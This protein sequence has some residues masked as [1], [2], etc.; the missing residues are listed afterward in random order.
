MP[1]FRQS[2]TGPP[3]GEFE[4]NRTSSQA[5]NLVGWW[6]CVGP[7]A[8]GIIRDYARGQNLAISASM[9][10]VAG[11]YGGA[12]L[13]FS[14]GYAKTSRTVT[15]KRRG[16]TMS[17]WCRPLNLTFTEGLLINCGQDSGGYALGVHQ[18]NLRG[19]ANMI[20]WYNTTYAL[21]VDRYHLAVM[22]CTESGVLTIYGNGAST[23]S[24][25]GQNP[26]APLAGVSLGY[27][28]Y[29]ARL[30]YGNAFDFRVYERA[31]SAAEVWQLYDPITRWELYKPLRRFWAVGLTGGVP[32][33]EPPTAPSGLSATAIDSGQ[34]DL[35]WTDES[36][37][38]TGFKIQRSTN[39]VTF[40]DLD[41][42]AAEAE[43]YSDTPCAANTRYW[44][45]VCATNTGGD[46][47]YTDAANAKTAPDAASKHYKF[48]LVNG[49]QVEQSDGRYLALVDGVVEPDTVAGIGWLY[50]DKNDNAL[51][52][53]EGDG[54]VNVVAVVGGAVTGHDLFSTS[55]ADTT[56]AASPVD[57]D[58]IIGNATPK[59]SKL[60]RSVPDAN[61]LNV[62]GIANGETRP[63]WKAALDGTN[64]A[65]LTSAASA[66]PGTSLV[67]AHRDH[68]HPI[69]SSSA[70]GAAASLLA[71][72]ASGHLTLEQLNTTANHTTT[73]LTDHIGEHT[74]A[75]GVVVDNNLVLAATKTIKGTTY[76]LAD[77]AATSFTLG[78]QMAHII[79]T[80]GGG[81]NASGMANCWPIG[82]TA[83][84]TK[85]YG[86][87]NFLVWTG[88]LTG[89]TKTDYNVNVSAHTD[90]KVYIE[91]RLGGAIS[92]T[93]T[94]LGA[95]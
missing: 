71:T 80:T 22:A 41:T 68:V 54:T 73:T 32:P 59:W 51:K 82:G 35:A 38:E 25:S 64:P 72:D 29:G 44:Y 43:S 86:G 18:G 15:T 6:P 87:A 65:T 67:A 53:K 17:F 12:A 89:T 79:F 42:A 10:W 49:G 5:D 93:V 24:W 74:G 52:Y 4:I 28:D 90:G 95:G 63:S 26:Y 70:P 34:I 3:D 30:F 36:A 2:F 88:A 75:H 77:D 21:T 58:I 40:A 11:A 78:T 83:Y 48:L 94:I 76:N 91:N 19:L 61:V 62:L 81:I 7:S 57:G 8:G 37:D 69:T 56:G 50:V 84:C 31:L 9:S 92:V 27:G 47:D 85:M 20:A 39:G 60:A 46:S 55:H 23:A 33:V 1:R 14:G 16:W 45:K 66:A 13:N